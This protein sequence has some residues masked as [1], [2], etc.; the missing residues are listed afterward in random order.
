MGR[1]EKRACLNCGEPFAADARNARHPRYCTVAACKAASKRARQATWLAK[2][3]N[4]DYQRG[5]ESVA[6]VKAWR[7]A[8]PGY[9]RRT[10]LPPAPGQEDWINATPAAHPPPPASEPTPPAQTACNAPGVPLQALLNSQPIVLVGLIAHIW[11][12]A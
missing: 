2:P 5:P 8:H 12:S 7:A 4:R 3:E 1:T 11:G 9:S 6:R 10:P